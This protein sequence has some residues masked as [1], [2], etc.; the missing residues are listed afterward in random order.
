MT[1]LAIYFN[2]DSAV[3]IKFDDTIVKMYQVQKAVEDRI[4][5][6]EDPAEEYAKVEAEAEAAL[7]NLQSI[8]DSLESINN[9]HSSD[10]NIIQFM[11]ENC[12]NR[13][14]LENLEKLTTVT[15]ELIDAD[16]VP[17]DIRALADGEEKN[18]H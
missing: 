7:A 9:H 17:D 2:K 5:N 16:E 1:T 3:E 4:L 10:S 8:N 6:A 18:S 15:E 14:T 13:M 11:I 12:E